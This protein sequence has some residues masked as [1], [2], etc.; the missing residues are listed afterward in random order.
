MQLKVIKS[1]AIYRDRNSQ[2][3]FRFRVEPEPQRKCKMG[4]SNQYTTSWQPVALS[5]SK[6]HIADE[7]LTWID[8][9]VLNMFAFMN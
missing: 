8:Y 4:I 9:S 6:R 3:L 7:F 5:N 1:V 2:Y